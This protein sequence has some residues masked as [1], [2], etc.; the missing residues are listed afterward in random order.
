MP[1]PA[2]ARA[3]GSLPFASDSFVSDT[4]KEGTEAARAYLVTEAEAGPLA[5]PRLAVVPELVEPA[6]LAHG[7]PSQAQ[8]LGMHTDPA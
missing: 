1:D 3:L 8:P 5:C 2:R 4:A 7:A 6:V